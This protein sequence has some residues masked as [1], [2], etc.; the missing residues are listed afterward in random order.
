[1]RNKQQKTKTHQATRTTHQ[2]QTKQHEQAIETHHI[3][4]GLV[5]RDLADH[6]GLYLLQFLQHGPFR[7][8]HYRIPFVRDRFVDRGRGSRPD[9][10]AESRGGIVRGV[11]RDVRR[12]VEIE[13]LMMM[14]SLSLA[15]FF[16]LGACKT[17]LAG[18]S[19]WLAR[20]RLLR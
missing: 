1:M 17:L 13:A 8:K 6:E 3:P 12:A 5:I 7:P 16:L 2:K 18:Q 19:S 14:L 15:R 20:S 9:R 11:V 10:L 4:N